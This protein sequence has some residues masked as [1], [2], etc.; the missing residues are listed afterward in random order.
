M[1]SAAFA[2]NIGRILGV[3]APD[4]DDDGASG[5]HTRP[6]RPVSGQFDI[7][8]AGAGRITRVRDQGSRPSLAA[9]RFGWKR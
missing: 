3:D 7:N 8:D 5:I 1:T 9:G 4:T 6:I 2:R